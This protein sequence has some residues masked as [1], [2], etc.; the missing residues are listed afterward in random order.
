MVNITKRI[1]ISKALLVL[2][3]QGIKAGDTIEEKKRREMVR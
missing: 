2:V 3:K 1:V